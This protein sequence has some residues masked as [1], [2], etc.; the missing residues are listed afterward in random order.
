MLHISTLL[1]YISVPYH[2]IATNSNEEMVQLVHGTSMAQTI[3]YPTYPSW[4]YC[5]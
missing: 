4:I 2:D 3:G 5:V 1:S